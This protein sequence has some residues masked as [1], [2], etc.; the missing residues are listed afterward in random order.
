MF[1]SKK[2]KKTE[3]KLKLL[4]LENVK[5][6]CKADTKENVIRAVGQMLVDTGYVEQP[7]VDAMVKREES[8]STYMGNELALPH[9]VEEAKKEIK[10]SGIAVMIFPEGT[11]W[12]AEKAK[13]VVGIAGVGEEHLQ[14]LSV[15]ADKV[16]EEGNVEKLTKGSADEVYEMLKGEDMG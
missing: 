16:L 13:I 9:G 10:A 4:Y 5:V 6:G 1:F 12:G 7:Y 14:I 15:L 11:E 8:F 2:E 3:K